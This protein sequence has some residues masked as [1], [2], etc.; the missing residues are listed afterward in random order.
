MT[1]FEEI[2]RD[3]DWREAELAA[4][5]MVLASERLTENQK[6]VLLRAGWAMLYAHYEG[7]CKFALTIYFNALESS[8][9]KCSAFKLKTQAFALTD[10]LK[11]MRSLSPVEFLIKIRGFENDI[12]D[13]PITFPEVDTESNLWPK[14]L[15]RLL[16]DADLKV[17]SLVAHYHTIA[18]LVNRRNKI[19][20]GEKDIIRESDHYISYEDAVVEIMIDLALTIDK[21]ISGN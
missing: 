5:R 20:H 19:T 1:P 17:E 18:T 8:G 7:F 16:D 11:R 21:K 4:L 6:H 15:T 2:A 13:K 9:A 14:T 10:K 12:L 3:L